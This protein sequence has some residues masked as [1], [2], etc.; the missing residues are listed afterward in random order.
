[1]S[2]NIKSTIFVKIEVFEQLLS[3]I[4]EPQLTCVNEDLKIIDN[5][6]FDKKEAF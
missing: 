3:F 6:E 1:M 2:Q 5:K 4:F